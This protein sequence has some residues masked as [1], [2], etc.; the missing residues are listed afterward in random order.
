MPFEPNAASIAPDGTTSTLGD[1]EIA[2]LNILNFKAL[3]SGDSTEVNY[4]SSH[5]S[6]IAFSISTSAVTRPA[7]Y[8]RIFKVFTHS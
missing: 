7:K 5:A 1:L 4:F 2:T 8:S 6:T 3:E